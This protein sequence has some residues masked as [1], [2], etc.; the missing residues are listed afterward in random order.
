MSVGYQIGEAVQMVKNTKAIQNLADQYD[1]L[2]GLSNQYN[3]LNSLANPS[4]PQKHEAFCKQ[5]L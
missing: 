4:Y 5:F 2:S 3:R 1:N